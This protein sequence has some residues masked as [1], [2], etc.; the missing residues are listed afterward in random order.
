MGLLNPALLVL[1]LA[2]AVPIILHLFQRHQGPRVVFP[3]LRYLR[4][5]EK[6]SAR[7][8]KLR[9]LLL[10]LLRVAAVLLLA[11]AAARPFALSGG[12]GHEPTAVVIVL[13]NSMST[14]AVVGDRRVIDELKDLALA[15]LDGAGP[16]DR[17]WLLRAGAPWEPAL[18]GDPAAT[19]ARVRETEPTG[20]AADFTAALAHARALL[21]AG[22]EG[23]AAE[24][25]L[26][27]D[28]QATNFPSGTAP[29]RD[30]PAVVVWVANT[31]PSRNVSVGRVEIGGGLPPTAGERSS[32][33]AV[34]EGAAAEDSVRVRLSVDGRVV[35]AGVAP[36]GAG[37]VLP[38]PGRPAGL[39]AGWVETDADG[40]RADDRRYFMLRVVPPPAVAVS[41]DLGFVEEAL[42]VMETA[43]RVR[44]APLAA[45]D[46]AILATGVR[47]ESV[48]DGR[49]AIILPPESPLELPAV[50]RRLGEAGV[51]WRYE[52]ASASG[53][54]RF[55][56]D[57]LSDPLMRP[58]ERVRL[59]QVYA[60]RP[61]GVVADT[62]LLRLR[63]GLD[64]AVR[65][66]RARGGQY[67]LLASPLSSAATTLPT[68]AAM[69]PLLDRLVGAWAVA[70]PP[71]AE[72]EAGEGVTLPEG[73][74][75]V[76][77]PDGRVDPAAPGEFRAGPEQGVY[78]VLAGNTVLNAFA[79]NSPRAES[80]LSRLDR[81]RINEFV[82]GREVE[83]ADSHAEWVNETYRNRL[84]HELWR[85][86]LLFVL[87]VLAVEASVAATG[88][89]LRAGTD[90]VSTS[91][92]PP[93]RS[94]PLSGATARSTE[95]A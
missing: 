28:L 18:P 41:G 15:S 78:Y 45:A 57:T 63:E 49:T 51:P 87:L 50:N 54:S 69:V 64:W 90:T 47:L 26:L 34:V 61:Q 58:L 74:T 29:P 44:R 81:R 72:L 30:G 19:A 33:V 36:V 73:T 93:Q 52:P 35:A 37:A 77:R 42:A 89:A 4:R 60:L 16:D 55:A 75:A 22:A 67:I 8:I 31:Q 10:M 76:R 23:R 62:V 95:P 94:A 68:S 53:E 85:P 79:V 65:G 9:Q 25:H 82:G 48:P 88:R 27:S 17:F 86:A 71:S 20:A 32:A 84:G 38:L 13:D 2:A 91:P 6:E 5:A 3:A 24:I 14:G 46:V 1:G 80:E 59:T 7:Q 39:Y 12:A 21:A 70:Q 56:T 83:L 66:E 43:G 92:P 11:V 40:L